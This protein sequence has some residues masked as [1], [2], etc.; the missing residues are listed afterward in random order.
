MVISL[1]GNIAIKVHSQQ[2][3]STAVTFHDV[4]FNF[5][6]FSETSL[7]NECLLDNVTCDAGK[8][9]VDYVANYSCE[10]PAWK[11]GDDC[12][13]GEIYFFEIFLFCITFILLD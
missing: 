5:D 11:T 10:C 8:I 3:A 2:K 1:N 9:C 12:T 4:V 7:L 13:Q 6:I